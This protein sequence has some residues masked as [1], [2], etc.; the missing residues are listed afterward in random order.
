MLDP[1]TDKAIDRLAD[2]VLTLFGLAFGWL[3]LV[4]LLVLVLLCEVFHA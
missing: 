2:K 1:E 3:F 4:S